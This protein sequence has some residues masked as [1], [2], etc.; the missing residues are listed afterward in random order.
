MSKPHQMQNKKKINQYRD[1]RKY[2][3]YTLK[4][5]RVGTNIQSTGIYGFSGDDIIIY[6]ETEKD[7]DPLS[8][9]IFS[10]YI[11]SDKNFLS[12]SFKLKKEKN[13]LKIPNID[14]SEI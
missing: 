6:V 7:D 12:S 13:I 14:L 10:Q 3:R 11:G 4:M 1:I 5:T 8:S 9:I 2:S